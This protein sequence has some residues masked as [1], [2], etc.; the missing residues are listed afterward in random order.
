MSNVR[1]TPAHRR[2]AALVLILFLVVPLVAVVALAVDYGYLIKVRA[3][4]QRA[5][6]MAALAAVRDLLPDANGHQNQA[7]VRATVRDYVEEHFGSTF[8]VSNADMQMGRYDPATIYSQVD[9]LTSGVW[10][11]LRITLRRDSTANSPV[12]LFFAPVIGVNSSDVVATATAVLQKARDMPPGSDILPFAV[13][14]SEWNSLSDGDE[15]SIYGDGRMQDQF[16]NNIPGNWGTVDI[17]A[18]NNSTSNLS[19][20]IRNGLHQSHLDALHQ[21]GRLAESTHIDG[22]AETWLQADPGLSSG[23]ASSVQAIHGES[24]LIP[25]FDAQQ[26]AGGNNLEYRIVG[27]GVVDVVSSNWH[28]AN[29][30]YVEVRKSY[31]Y[32]GL[33]HPH[34]DLSATSGFITGAFTSPVLVE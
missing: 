10:D 29:N 18:E 2:G 17:G 9:L 23:I 1:I 27:W 25:L 11:T 15:W 14:L 13:P 34:P 4:V 30:T 3:D 26:V 33:L 22:S 5:A 24:R 8:T 19:D 20:Q 7:V 21:D 6:D 32:D 12:S 28:G 16:G 31:M